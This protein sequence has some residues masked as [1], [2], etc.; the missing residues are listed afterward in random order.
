MNIKCVYEL[1]TKRYGYM[2]ES[3]MP[4]SSLFAL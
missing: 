3:A 1:N 2:N 4:T